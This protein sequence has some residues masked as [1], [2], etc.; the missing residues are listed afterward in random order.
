MSQEVRLERQGFTCCHAGSGGGYFGKMKPLG[1]RCRCAMSPGS[2]VAPGVHL[3]AVHD[4]DAPVRSREGSQ[5]WRV[6]MRR[7]E[8]RKC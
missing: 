2:S 1:L 7:G 6:C 3:V 4:R 5:L 8:A